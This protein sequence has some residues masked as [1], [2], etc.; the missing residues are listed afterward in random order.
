MYLSRYAG[1][2]CS[3]AD[4]VAIAVMV[5]DSVAVTVAV[6]DWVAVAVT[7]VG[8]VTAAVADCTAVAV[9]VIDSVTGVGYRPGRDI[10]TSDH[11][12]A[13]GRVIAKEMGTY[14]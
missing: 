10:M 14:G 1:F 7:V 12:I 5:V 6:A 4:W 11:G 2:F 8:S 13:E 3:V 9:T